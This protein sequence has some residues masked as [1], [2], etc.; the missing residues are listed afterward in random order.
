M[1]IVSKDQVIESWGMLIEN[2]QGRANEVFQSTEDFIRERKAP[3][4]KTKR[5]QLAP[6]VVG[7]LFGTKRDFLV[8]NDSHLAAYDIFINVRDYGDNLDVSWYM[9]YKPS[10]LKSLLSFFRLPT[11]ALSELDLFEQQDLRAY[12]TVA[13]H[14]TLKAVESL[15]QKLDQD[16]TRIN[17]ESK[18][19]LGVS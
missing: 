4:L 16:T 12:A 14:S 19:F 8:V 1:A 3:L 6:S 9:T 15:M 17:R 10:F 11:F 7:S 13:H 18:G 2:A 5:E